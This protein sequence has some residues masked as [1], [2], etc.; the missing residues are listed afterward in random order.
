MP[1][2]DAAFARRRPETTASGA[3]GMLIERLTPGHASEYR[4]LMLEAYA[5]HPDAFTSS[6][7]ERAGLPISWWES[8][9]GEGQDSSDVVFGAIST[10]AIVGVAGLSFQ[11]RQKIRH[12]ATLFGMYV[13]VARR[14]R[15]LGR[16]L[17]EYSLACA[18]ERSG[19]S[20]VQLTVTLGNQAAE[21]LY[22]RCGFVRFGLEPNAV[23]VG[24]EFVAKIHMWRS[25]ANTHGRCT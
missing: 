18:S 24:D 16:Q 11:T 6:A 7:A 8:R 5:R 25:V 13:P 21:V 4:N 23:A 9:L 10:G 15:S 22:E 1:S 2:F 3:Q 20:V 12:K 14:G 17:V 19:V